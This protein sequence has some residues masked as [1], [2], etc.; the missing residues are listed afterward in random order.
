MYLANITPPLVGF[1]SI[2]DLI[3]HKK[4]SAVEEKS[5]FEKIMEQIENVQDGQV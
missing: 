2:E 4:S 1:N 3:L 5:Q